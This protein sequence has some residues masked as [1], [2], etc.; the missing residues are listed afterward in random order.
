MHK[1]LTLALALVVFGCPSKEGEQ[2]DAN[3]GGAGGGG[4]AGG[5]TGATAP[6][7][8]PLASLDSAPFMNEVWNMS[9][10]QV[11]I[12]Y[13]ARENVRVSAQCRNAAG[14]LGCS[15]L[16]PIRGGAPVTLSKSELGGRPAGALAC[17]K[18]NNSMMTGLNQKGDEET[19]CRFPDG[20]WLSTNTLEQYGVKVQ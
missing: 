2:K 16:G 1:A 7:T 20:S 4:G 18:L 11:Q 17:K 15:A 9:G 19:F 12:L 5:P 13:Y 3:A 14:Q 8:G 6:A 10:E